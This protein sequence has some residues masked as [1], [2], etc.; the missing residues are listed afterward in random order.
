M[1]ISEYRIGNLVELF[2]VV[3]TIQRSDFSETEHGIAIESGKPIKLTGK[4][5]ENFG[6][7]KRQNDYL[8]E[9]EHFKLFAQEDTTFNSCCFFINR[10]MSMTENQVD[11][12]CN[13]QY[14]HRLQNLYFALS[15]DELVVSSLVA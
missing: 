6:F 14:V 9:T 7:R 10:K 12:I 2:G 5:L 13:C 1:K 15:G 3:A 8:L 4:W 11:F